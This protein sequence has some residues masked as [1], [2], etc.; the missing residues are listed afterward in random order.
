[1]NKRDTLLEH[2][3]RLYVVEQMTALDVAE[4]VGVDE[5][6]IRR[7]KSEFKWD[8][9]REQ[10]I[11]TKQMFHEELFN[12]ARKLMASIELDMD[13]QEKIDPG[14]MFAF[15]KLLPMITKVKAYEDDVASKNINDESKELTP[16][17]IKEINETFL[18]IKSDD[19]E[20]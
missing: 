9:K 8:Y 14:R 17:F 19:E 5:R 18:G 15:T 6:T 13:N 1:M 12:F 2:A 20:E 7:W 10:Y 16:E 3:Q 4:R 11:S